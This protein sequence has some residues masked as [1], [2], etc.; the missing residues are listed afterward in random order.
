M[1]RLLWIFALAAAVIG[2]AQ[3]QGTPERTVVVV[4]FDGFSPAELDAT[5]NTPNFDRIKREGAWSRHLVPAFPTISLIN[6]T[7]FETGC[8]PSH[9]GVMSN[10]F[11]DPKMGLFGEKLSVADAGWHTGCE[12]IWEAAERQGVH[13]AVYNWVG[14][15][16]KAKGNR[17][18]FIN[19]N[20]PWEKRESDEQILADALKR[21][22]DNGPNHP[23]LVALYFNSP[24]HV[25]HEFGVK[26][27]ETQ[28]SVRMVDGITGRL[29]QALASLPPGREGTLVIG[30]DHGMMDVGPLVNV[31]RLMAMFDIKAKQATDGASAFLYLDPG[32]SAD[33]VVKA[34]NGGGYSYAFTAYKKGHFPSY[35]HLGDGPRVPDVMI[36]TKPPYWIVGPEVMPWWARAIGVNT[37]WSPVFTPFAG[38]IKATHGYPP[39]IVQMHGNFFLWGAGVKKGYTIA[40]L[41]MIDI[42]PTVMKLLGLESG[43]PVDGK[44]VV[45]ALSP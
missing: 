22:A 34:L 31:G 21:I 3:A 37:F 2:S 18:S 5:R 40:K 13:A 15:F 41:D 6:H 43:R 24:D 30:T 20:V 17:A 4:L 10:S 45:G 12:S 8:W 38:G 11:Y 26:A 14:R 7:T 27:P 42:H 33:R 25:A 28:A 1:R 44:P 23:R 19:P 36:V 9:H 35:V 32:E 39:G 16:S 29:M